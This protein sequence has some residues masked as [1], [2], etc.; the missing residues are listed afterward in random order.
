MALWASSAAASAPRPSASAPQSSGPEVG[1][2][3]KDVLDGVVDGAAK[4]L[5]PCSW[6]ILLPRKARQLL[7]GAIG[8]QGELHLHRAAR[9]VVR[10]VGCVL[11]HGTRGGVLGEALGGPGLRP[12]VGPGTRCTSSSR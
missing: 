12:A 7:L 2:T 5:V 1:H 8:D 4:A 10:L 3:F 6:V 11:H 9:S